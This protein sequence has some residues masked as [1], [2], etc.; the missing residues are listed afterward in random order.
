MKAKWTDDSYRER[1]SMSSPRSEAHRAKISEAIR[2]K[3]A[4]PDYRAKT[5]KGIHG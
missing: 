1:A 3:W 5:L 4:D 2:A